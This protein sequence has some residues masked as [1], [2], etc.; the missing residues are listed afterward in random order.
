MRTARRKRGRERD[1][2]GKRD[3]GRKPLI[4]SVSRSTDT[5]CS[6]CSEF[7]F[8][9]LLLRTYSTCDNRVQV[10]WSVDLLHTNSIEMHCVCVCVCVS[11]FTLNFLNELMQHYGII[12]CELSKSLNEMY[13]IQ[14]YK[15]MY[16]AYIWRELKG[17]KWKWPKRYGWWRRRR[18]R[19]RWW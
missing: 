8:L 7:L 6:R 1:W 16:Y 14:N 9:L 13:S 15:D 2:E 10:L 12:N 19:W 3:S 4:I 17:C 5:E 18:R 11:V